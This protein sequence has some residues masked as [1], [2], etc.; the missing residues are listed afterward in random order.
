MARISV[1]ALFSVFLLHAYGKLSLQR[2]DTGSKFLP[3][4]INTW[5]PPFTNATSEGYLVFTIIVPHV[6]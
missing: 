3:M 4:V 6:L 1:I 5:G 2:T